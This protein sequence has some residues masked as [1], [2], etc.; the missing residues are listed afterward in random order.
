MPNF[1]L[2]I[3]SGTTN[4]RTQIF[5]SEWNVTGKAQ[6]GLSLSTPQQ[7]LVEQSAEELWD[8][9]LSVIREA[10]VD[11]N[12]D[13]SEISALGITSQRSCCV[14]WERS[15]GKPL[16]PIISWQDLRGT[17]RSKELTKLGFPQFSAAAACKLESAL[18]LIENG[19]LRMQKNELCWGNVDSYIAFQLSGGSLHAT[20]FSQACT[21]GYFDFESQQWN[22]ALI[23]LQGLEISMFPA[24]VD[25]SSQ[26]GTCDTTL[27]GSAIPINAIVGDQQSATIAQNCTN[28]GDLKFTFGTSG[29]CNIH[30]GT[31]IK[32]IPGAYPLVLQRRNGHTEYCIEAMIVTAGATLEWLGHTLGIRN[33]STNL[34]RILEDIEKTQDVLVL[35]AFQGLGSPHM[36]SDR[37]AQISGL[38]L[39]TNPQHIIYAALE[40]IA[41]RTRDILEHTENYISLP[42]LTSIRVDGGLTRSDTFTKILANVTQKSISISAYPEATVLGAARLAMQASTNS[43]DAFL[44]PHPPHVCPPDITTKIYYDKQYEHW[45]KSFSLPGASE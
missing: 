42:S 2:A 6:R 20:D 30:T 35:P 34:D 32:I 13:A 28:P 33:I 39:S 40:G 3:D 15:T 43:P 21:T 45:K 4:V 5:D 18:A 25:T 14:I 10:I 31:E 37:A 44:S 16:T 23:D 11:G 36:R 29:T 26:L 41:F 7:G 27:L 12:L 38:T 9:V 1:V 22:Q 17:E 19:Q 8:A 24:L